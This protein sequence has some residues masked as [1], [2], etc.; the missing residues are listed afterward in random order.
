MT[1]RKR[2]NPMWRCPVCKR[3]F[4]NRNQSH[5][6]ARHNL[7]PHF[8]GK[9]PCI[10]QLYQLFLAEIR[11]CGPVIVLPEKTR[12]AFQ[13]RMSF[14]AIQVQRS[15]IIG[16]LVLARRYEQPCFHRIESFS[17]QNHTHNFRLT[18]PEDLNELRPFIVKAYAVGQQKHLSNHPGSF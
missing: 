18:K 9:P 7:R 6:C 10:R 4:A 8:A 3:Q 2:L 1:S 13:V 12:I 5:S 15:K 16:H 11:R 14:A 17:R